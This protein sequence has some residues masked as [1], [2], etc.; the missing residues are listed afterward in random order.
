MHYAETQN[1]WIELTYNWMLML[2][3]DSDV[4]VLPEFT[5]GPHTYRLVKRDSQVELYADGALTATLPAGAYTV[6]Q[7]ELNGWG[8][9]YA[10]YEAYWEHV[11]YTRGAYAPAELPS[12]P[13]MPATG[14]IFI[15]KRNGDEPLLTTT[16]VLSDPLVSYVTD[17][18]GNAA[19]GVNLAFSISRYPQ[20]ATGQELTKTSEL[21]GES[22]LADVRLKLGNIPAEYDVKAE[23]QSCTA[24]TSTVTFT[25]CGKVPND[26]FSQGGQM[27]SSTCYANNNCQ[28]DPDATIGWRG[29][30]LTSLA[31]LINYYN[32]SVYSGIPRTN[33]GDLNTY[34][35]DLPGYGG[36][37]RNNDVEFSAIR[38]YSSGRVSF[39]DRYD[40]D[41]PYSRESLLDTADGLIRSGIPLMFRVG[42][43]HFIL[44]IGKC[45]SSFV[46]ADPAGGREYLYNPANPPQGRLFRGLRVF[47][48]Y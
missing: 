32:S 36:Y 27:W 38:R 15:D 6:N 9:E 45:G 39:V 30:A 21:T 8:A 10:P 18:E 26:H 4:V 1:D 33:P 34:L 11:A 22:G 40:V 44:V 12:P 14:N 37:N 43:P 46:V 24:E 31:T 25:C 35:R 28:I 7:L 48:S 17:S 16:G 47:S 19:A 41:D 5:A 3:A 23:C 42:G 13:D 29:C 20:G 2:V